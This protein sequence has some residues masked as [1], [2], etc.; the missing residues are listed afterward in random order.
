MLFNLI[1]S[2]L[3]LL[4]IL[5]MA[6]TREGVGQWLNIKAPKSEGYHVFILSRSSHCDSI[7]KKGELSLD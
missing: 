7:V 2:Y 1:E 4:R 6:L 3:G 5:D